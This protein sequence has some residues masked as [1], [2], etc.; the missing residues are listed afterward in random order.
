MKTIHDIKQHNIELAQRIRETRQAL[1]QDGQNS[2]IAYELWVR[3]REFRSWHIAY[4]LIRGK[5]YE[6]IEPKVGEFN[7]PNW[8]FVNQ[9]LGDFHYEDVRISA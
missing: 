3:S 4:C 1:K 7:E 8:S 6:Q 9:I 2:D 5:S